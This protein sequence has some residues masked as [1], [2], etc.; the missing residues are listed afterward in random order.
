[1]PWHP[2]YSPDGQLVYVPVKES[3]GVTVVY[4]DQRLAMAEVKGRGIAQPHGSAV[5]PDGKWLFVSNNNM[6]GDHMADAGGMTHDANGTV[7]VVDTKSLKIAKVIE[8]G[9]N[10]TGIGLARGN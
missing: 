6:K 10:A 2:S 7:V 5:S 8:V 3:N 4:M 1:M 9:P